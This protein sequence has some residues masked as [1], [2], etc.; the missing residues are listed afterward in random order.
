MIQNFGLIFQNSIEQYFKKIKLIPPQIYLTPFT[1][2]FQFLEFFSLIIFSG[3]EKG[4]CLVTANINFLQM[5]GHSL[6]EEKITDPEILENIISEFANGISANAS[7]DLHDDYDILPPIQ[8]MEKILEAI[9]CGGT[10]INQ[11]IIN[12][13][14]IKCMVYIGQQ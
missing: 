14:H 11:L 8:N 5:L 2:K 3:S 12:T 1:E 7:R 6:L 9:Q 10:K 4:F 13:D